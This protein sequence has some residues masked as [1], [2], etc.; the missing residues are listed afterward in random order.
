[1]KHHY[2]IKKTFYSE[3]YP[4]DITDENY[5]RYQ[6]VFKKLGLKNI[7]DYHDLYNQRDTLLLE[8]VFENF[9]NMC[10]EI[11]ELDPAHF[12]SAPGQA[13]EACLKKTRV[14]LEL[15]TDYDMLLMVEKGIRSGMCQAIHRYAKANNKYMKNHSKNFESSYLMLNT[16]NLY[17]WAMSQQLPVNSSKWVKELSK[18]NESFIKGYDESSDKGYFLEVDVEYLKK[19]LSLHRDLSFLPERNKIKKCNKLVCNI[20]D[21]KKYVVQISALKQALNHGL[22]LK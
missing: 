16:N 14:K 17:G 11:Y 3:S 9:R 15:L 19:W 8:D 18:F 1:M 22:I 10:T 7:G 6:K 2:Q 5:T 21:K 12:L 4:E 13:W 20:Q